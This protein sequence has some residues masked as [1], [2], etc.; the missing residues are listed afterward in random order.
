MASPSTPDMQIAPQRAKQLLENL[1]TVTRQIQA[2]NKSSRAVSAIPLPIRHPK[3]PPP[4]T[5][6]PRSYNP[7]LN[8][9]LPSSLTTPTNPPSQIRLT[10]VSKLHPA[11]AILAL[12]RPPSSPSPSTNTTPPL[13][14]FGE[15]YAQELATKAAVLPRSIKW[16]F[17]GALQSNKCKSLAEIPNLW[18]VESVDSVKK[19]DLLERGRREW[20]ERGKGEG[21]GEEKMN[22]ED[23]LLRV[24]VQV[25]TSG[26]DSKSGVQ[27]GGQ[28][29]ELCRHIRQNCPHLRLQGLMTI[30]AIARSVSSQAEGAEAE[31]E[32]F[33]CLRKERDRVQEILGGESLELSMGMS[34]DFESAI[35][36]GSDEVRVGS[37]IFGERPRREDAVV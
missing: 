13:T 22:G 7:P 15:N 4:L 5:P 24:F 20:V 31:N 6:L 21:E 3:N 12:H 33:S 1:S 14:H 29:V 35:R 34:G 11:S 37:G 19:A 2:A 18:A 36:A 28:V 32:D 16:H 17:I 27:P 10:A 9:L 23:A 30:G 26:E 8:H 25:N